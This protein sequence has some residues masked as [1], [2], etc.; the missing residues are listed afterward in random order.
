MLFAD[1]AVRVLTFVA[2]AGGLAVAC[3]YR[4]ASAPAERLY[5]FEVDATRVRS[6]GPDAQ[7]C[8]RVR[9]RADAPFALFYDTISGFAYEPGYR[10]LLQVARRAVDRPTPDGSTAGYRLVAVL[11][12]VP[13]T[14]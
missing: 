9:E 5:V 1:L 3:A 4:A 7:E 10:Y 12:K 6:P 2:A 11:S 14:S 8:L 13:A